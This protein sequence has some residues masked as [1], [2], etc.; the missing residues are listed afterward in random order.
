MSAIESRIDVNMPR[1]RV[2]DMGGV[3]F[4][5]SSGIAVIIKTLRRT[6]EIGGKFKV[7]NVAPQPMKVIDAAGICRLVDISAAE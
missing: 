6:T 4:M 2:L 5:D 1:D 7:T 3:T